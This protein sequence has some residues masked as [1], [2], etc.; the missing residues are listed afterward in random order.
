LLLNNYNLFNFNSYLECS[1]QR[2]AINLEVCLLQ[3]A[4]VFSEEATKHYRWYW[5]FTFCLT[6]CLGPKQILGSKINMHTH[7]HHCTL[8]MQRVTVC[9]KCN[10]EPKSWLNEVNR[11]VWKW[12]YEFARDFPNKY[13]WCLLWSDYAYSIYLLTPSIKLRF[14]A[15]P[16]ILTEIFF[17][18]FLN[19][20]LIL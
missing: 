5:I 6:S 4:A 10:L 9:Q 17:S 3:I 18:N 14:V 15:F 16:N 2:L 1:D 12:F 13:L 20:K 8:W 19:F 7:R 11:C